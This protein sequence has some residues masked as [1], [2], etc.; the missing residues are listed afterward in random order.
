MNLNPLNGMILVVNEIPCLIIDIIPE[1][2]LY[3]KFA[4][5]IYKSSF[6]IIC[7]YEIG[8]IPY[9]GNP[10]VPVLKLWESFK[11]M[12]KSGNIAWV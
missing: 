9:E 4:L 10:D 3:C 8:N 11:N 7:M 2:K 5:V 12:N 6:E 1:N